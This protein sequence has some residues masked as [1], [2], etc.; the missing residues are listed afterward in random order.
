MG[1]RRYY[2]GKKKELSEDYYEV[3]YDELIK[4]G[5]RIVV[6]HG[7][8]TFP[9]KEDTIPMRF[10]TPYGANKQGWKENVGDS[11]QCLC[12]NLCGRKGNC[13]TLLSGSGD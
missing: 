7:S 4:N 6:K 12:E 2:K 11:G 3:P 13:K 10:E 8:E 1:I 5:G 9:G